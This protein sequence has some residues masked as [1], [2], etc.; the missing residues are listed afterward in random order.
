[1]SEFKVPQLKQEK[2]VTTQQDVARGVPDISPSMP[3]MSKAQIAMNTKGIPLAGTLGSPAYWD[4]QHD[5]E[6]PGMIVA[7]HNLLRKPFK[8]TMAEFNAMLRGE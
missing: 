2:Q 7:K 1:M 4:I 8:G 3:D 6:A 5:P